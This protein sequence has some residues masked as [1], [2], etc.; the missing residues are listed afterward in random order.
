MVAY[1]EKLL[2]SQSVG[3]L[4]LHLEDC[5]PCRSLAAEQAQLRD[6]LLQAG[7]SLAGD[8]LEP[9]VMNRIFREQTFDLRR[10]VMR[11]RI[12]KA[13][14]SLAAAAAVVVVVFTG[15]QNSTATAAEV[16]AQ[17]IDAAR[18]LRSV[19]LK[20][21]VRNLPHDNFEL[22]GLDYDFI[23]IEMWK[24]FAEPPK[25][26]VEKEGR[27]AVM[28][29]ES[30]VMLMKR[31]NVAV[32][33]GPRDEF[34]AW[35]GRL[36][37]VEQVL[38][39]ELQRA[40]KMGWAL[41]LSKEKGADGSEKLVVV[42]EVPAQG[43]YTNEY[44]LNKSIHDAHTRRIYRFD[45]VSKRLESLEVF[46][47]TDAEQEVRVFEIAEIQYD[48]E[49]DPALFTLDLPDDVTWN[50]EPGVLE[51][52]DKYAKMNPRE[53]AQAIL[54]AAVDGNWDEA[55]KFG[56]LTGLSAEARTWF[57]GLEIISLGEPF[58]SGSYP[59]WFVP[60]EVRF[61]NGEVKKHNLAI[62]NDNPA[63]RY[64]FDGGF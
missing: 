31:V 5:D 32:R 24:E 25:W 35:L 62:R 34:G 23:P 12:A 6:R 49:L 45:A 41:E 21:N 59:G 64:V 40:E 42:I 46:V 55:A 16:F 47:R 17:A 43:D 1:A 4:R 61:R 50:E 8:S 30:A 22:I 29:G 10:H 51:E 37:N 14:L 27:V 26:R 54:Q 58:Q 63:G 57:T 20:L 18:N 33:W 15:L 39:R 28:D 38:D 2:D 7:Q 36:V 52:N 60:Y 44:L 11:S 19:Y 9:A 3:A 13:G 56:F 53:T 48:P